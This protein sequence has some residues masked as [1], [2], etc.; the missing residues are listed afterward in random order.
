MIERRDRK[1]GIKRERERKREREKAR[2]RQREREHGKRKT[3][4][5]Q[6][7]GKL[8]PRRLTNS[9]LIAS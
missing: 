6:E 1:R 3:W 5:T 4:H 9:S 2:E 8:F 7:I